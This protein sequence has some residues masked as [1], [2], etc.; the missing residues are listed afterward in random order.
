MPQPLQN[1]RRNLMQAQQH[2]AE[3]RHQH[4]RTCPRRIVNQG[5][6]RRCQHKD[7]DKGREA[8]KVGNAHPGSRLAEYQLVILQ[9]PCLGNGRYQADRQGSRQ[10]GGKVHQWHSHARKIAEQLRGLVDAVACH[11]QPLGHDGQVEV[12][13]HRQHDA[14]SRYRQGQG[15]NTLDNLPGGGTLRL[16]QGL[17]IPAIL[18]FNVPFQ[19]PVEI[20]QHQKA[21]HCTGKGT[22]AGTCRRKVQSPGQEQAGEQNHGDNPENLLHNLGDS[23]WR[24]ALPALQISP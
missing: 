22:Q 16:R 19:L 24:H 1:C 7:D 2:N 6:N 11:L 23:R 8:H 4:R 21:G 18:I 9:G 12:G 20:H 10:N 15:K 14:G 5:G 3:G 13:H 17:Y